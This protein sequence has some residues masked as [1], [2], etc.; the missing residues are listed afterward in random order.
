VFGLL[1]PVAAQKSSELTP[2]EM[3]GIWYPKSDLG[4]RQCAQLRRDGVGELHPGALQITH[5]QLT[6]WKGAGQHAL[7]FVTE[8]RPRRRQV[9]RV[10][11]LLDVYPYD[12]PKVLETYVF[13]LKKNELHWFKRSFDVVAERVDTFVYERCL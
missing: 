5:A 10:Q 1:A 11:G 6:E 3:R 12:A 2:V 13:E 4:T 7:V 8:S 9:W